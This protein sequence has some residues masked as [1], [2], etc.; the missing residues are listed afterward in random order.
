M[1]HDTQSESEDEIVDSIL[2]N[3]S[4]DRDREDPGNEEW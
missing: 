3:V 4:R 1:A 2:D